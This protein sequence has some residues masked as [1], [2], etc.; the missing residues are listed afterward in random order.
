ML[1]VSIPADN[2]RGPQYMEYALAAIH[3]ANP[4]R[5][6]MG[7]G[8]A[9]HQKNVTLLIRSPP[10]LAAA[11]ASQLSAHYPAATISRLADDALAA[12]SGL[13]TWSADLCLT[14]DLFPIRRYP[15]FDDVLNRNVSDPLTAIF[16]TLA[17]NGGDHTHP[18]IVLTVRPASRHRVRRAR[19]AVRRLTSP[20]FRAHPRL[21]RLLALGCTSQ[22]TVIRVLARVLSRVAC[23]GGRAIAPTPSFATSTRSHDREEDLQ[24][25]VDK[26]GRHLFEVH[27]RL[28]VS[29]GPGDAARAKAQLRRMAGAFGQFTVPRMARF[30]LTRIRRHRHLRHRRA[31]IPAVLRGTGHSLA[32]GHGHRACAGHAVHREPR[33]RTAR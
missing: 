26:L 19:A 13:A 6:P 29:V 15:Q 1:I 30:H 16:A 2:D 17:P 8:F 24:A 32:P 28:T 23:S 33:T 14:P 27:L 11:A 12:P 22:W 31:R 4:R 10:E 20:F 9:R 3:Q 18:A 21:A 7:F 25:A 5:L